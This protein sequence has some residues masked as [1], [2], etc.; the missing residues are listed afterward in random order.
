MGRLRYCDGGIYLWVLFNQKRR[1][2]MKA[3]IAGLIIF[4]TLFTQF[5]A[6]GYSDADPAA[7]RSDDSMQGFITVSLPRKD[8]LTLVSVL[9]VT[10][11]GETLGGIVE[12]DDPMTKRPAD[13]LELFNKFGALLA[14]SWIDNFGIERLAVDRGLLQNAD[15]LEGVYVLIQTGDPT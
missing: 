11:N 6:V 4:A 8:R 15:T 14:V 13:Y 12:Y 5:R 3:K 7:I 2:F 1:R 10:S 9:R